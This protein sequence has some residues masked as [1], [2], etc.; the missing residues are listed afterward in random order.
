M[1]V[2]RAAQPDQDIIPVALPAGETTILL[3]IG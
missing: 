3:K 1:E 2:E